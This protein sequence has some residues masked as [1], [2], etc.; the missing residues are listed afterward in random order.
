M[1]DN[2]N[3]ANADKLGIIVWLIMTS[4]PSDDLWCELADCLEAMALEFR[5]CADQR[6]KHFE[7]VNSIGKNLQGL[8]ESKKVDEIANAAPEVREVDRLLG[9]MIRSWWKIFE[10]SGRELER[11]R[12]PEPDAKIDLVVA[13]AKE[14]VDEAN[15]WILRIE[16]DYRE[17]NGEDCTA[18]PWW[19]LAERNKS[20]WDRFWAKRDRPKDIER[21]IWNRAM[22]Q[23][24]AEVGRTANL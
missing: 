5:K 18:E 3:I 1:F 24:H 21:Q 14:E 7:K 22:E 16:R 10:V 17:R 19:L 9:A 12:V 20:A 2:V 13:M 4:V 8:E 6:R 11:S 23:A 15:V